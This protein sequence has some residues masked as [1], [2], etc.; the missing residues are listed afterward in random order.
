MN[1]PNIWA[2][3]MIAVGLAMLLVF[4]RTTKKARSPIIDLGIFKHKAFS[5][6]C[7]SAYMN[8]SASATVAFFLSLYLQQI[9]AL[10]TFQAGLILLIQPVVQVL[11]TAKF[12][13]YS[14]RIAD[15]RILETLGMAIISVAVAMIIFLGTEVNY[16]YI[17]II[18]VLVGVG[19]GVFAAPNTNAV[20][21]S[22]PPKNR[23]EASGMVAL[24]RQIGMLTSFGVA[25]CCISVIMGSADNIGPETHDLFIDVIRAAFT[26]CLAMCVIGAITSWFRG[27]NVKKELASQ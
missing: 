9:G 23:G 4:I 11:L 13:S 21:S 3:A 16:V 20:I 7:I 10:T 1:L 18:L 6:A 26:I 24:V 25:M 19:Y 5:R 12:G 14:D 8:Y 2:I 27:S 17:G 15:K 22:V